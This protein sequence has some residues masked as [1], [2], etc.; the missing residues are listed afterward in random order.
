MLAVN[1]EEFG[2][3]YRDASC[4]HGHDRFQEMG[5]LRYR[6][7]AVVETDHVVPKRPPLLLRPGTGALKQGDE[8]LHEPA[9]K[10]GGKKTTKRRLNGGL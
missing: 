5:G 4:G 1:S 3:A 2:H 10:G 8:V 6:Q 7:I 9:I